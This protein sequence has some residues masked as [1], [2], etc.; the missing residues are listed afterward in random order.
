[1]IISTHEP[2]LQEG[3]PFFLGEVSEKNI[4]RMLDNPLSDARR[5]IIELRA[6]NPAYTRLPYF[7][8]LFHDALTYDF[9]F[10]TSED[11]AQYPEISGVIC[12]DD[13]WAMKAAFE[14]MS[15]DEM[16]RKMLGGELP[17]YDRRWRLIWNEVNEVPAWLRELF[18]IYGM[19]KNQGM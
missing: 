1:M 17:P 5:K 15:S 2:A 16:K 13:R 7:V 4:Y 9:T 3:G 19:R 18:I 11:L 10:L 12:G 8:V 14:H 6:D